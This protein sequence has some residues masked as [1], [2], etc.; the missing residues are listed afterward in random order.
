MN[1]YS[2][3]TKLSHTDADAFF[4]DMMHNDSYHNNSYLFF[5]IIISLIIIIIGTVLFLRNDAHSSKKH[6]KDDSAIG[7]AKKRLAKGE[8]TKKQFLEIK[9]EVK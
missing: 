2:T 6:S 7:I 5:C 4:N 1:I 8:I 3:I 9:K